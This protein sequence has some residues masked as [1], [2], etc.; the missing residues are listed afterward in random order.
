M[1][2]FLVFYVFQ[3]VSDT[4]DV[5]FSDEVESMKK[6]VKELKGNIYYKGYISMIKIDEKQ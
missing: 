2:T 1:L 5:T 3:D 4:E 6:I